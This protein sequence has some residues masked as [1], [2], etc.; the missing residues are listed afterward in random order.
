[1]AGTGAA[2]TMQSVDTDSIFN[3]RSFVLFRQSRVGLSVA[4]QRPAL[5][6]GGQIDNL[7]DSPLRPLGR[8]ANNAL[9]RLRC[10]E[11]DAAVADAYLGR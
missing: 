10:V 3:N 11:Y 1:M 6:L 9:T 4:A 7:T 5:P 8:S 2:M